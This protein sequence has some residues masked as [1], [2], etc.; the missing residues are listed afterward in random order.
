MLSAI[1]LS[2]PPRVRVR[3]TA[4]L[5]AAFFHDESSITIGGVRKCNSAWCCSTCVDTIVFLSKSSKK[6]MI[7]NAIFKLCEHKNLF[8]SSIYLRITVFVAFLT[9]INKLPQQPKKE[10]FF[11]YCIYFTSTVF[12][13]FTSTENPFTLKISFLLFFHKLLFQNKLINLTERNPLNTFC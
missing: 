10:F 12:T 7:D 5:S 3:A 4:K 13:F 2:Y 9:I 6:S 11:H 1:T 8:L